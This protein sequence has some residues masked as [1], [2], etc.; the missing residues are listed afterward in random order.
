MSRKPA[1]K[2]ETGLPLNEE[3]RHGTDTGQ[4]VEPESV[5]V[6]KTQEE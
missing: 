5:E 3:E 1:K 2:Q 4:E 6:D